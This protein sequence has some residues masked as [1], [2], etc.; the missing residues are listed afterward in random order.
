MTFNVTIGSDSFEVYG[1][2][3]AATSYLNGSRSTGAAA[4][5]GLVAD[6]QA[7]VLIQATRMIDMQSWQGT[8]VGTVGGAATVLQWPRSGVVDATGT[9]VPST[10]VPANVLTAVYELCAIFADDEDIANDGPT[11]LRGLGAGPVRIDYFAPTVP[12]DGS[13][14]PL[15]QPVARYVGQYLAEAAAINTGSIAT[16]TDGVSTFDQDDSDGNDIDPWA[17]S[18][19]E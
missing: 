14:S 19:P 9:A 5:R 6:D 13:A 11:N 4:F 18:W 16:G 3:P 8:A 12:L 10:S 15:P 17:R 1:G 2:L 7:R